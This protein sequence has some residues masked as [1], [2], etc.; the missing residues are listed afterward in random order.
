M[1]MVIMVIMAT[2]FG[3]TSWEFKTQNIL[4]QEVAAEVLPDDLTVLTLR[5]G[6]TSR[7][8]SAPN[9]RLVGSQNVSEA[10]RCSA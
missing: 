1:I 7:H 2:C 9:L 10:S 8:T 5:L 3:D 6:V 4:Q